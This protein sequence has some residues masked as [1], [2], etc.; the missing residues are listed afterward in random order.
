[1]DYKS[2][3]KKSYNLYPHKFDAKFSENVKAVKEKADE[4][5]NS[6]NG[7]KILDLGSGSGHHALYFQEKGF[8]PL[9]ID[10]SEAMIQLCKRKGLPARVMD[11]ENVSLPEEHYDGIWAYASL[12]HIPRANLPSVMEKLA[13]LLK[14]HG[15]LALT[16][17]EGQG[18]G[19]EAQEEYPGTQRW[20]TYF[21]EQ[22]MQSLCEPCFEILKNSKSTVKEG[23]IMNMM[24]KKRD[25]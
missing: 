6:L 8:D 3:T 20:F 5:L 14:P 22:E 11:M 7:K 13:S 12:L 18:E 25:L 1:M 2:E 21:T 9:C 17:K 4:F 23:T 19:F 10:I 16:V 15:I 24:M